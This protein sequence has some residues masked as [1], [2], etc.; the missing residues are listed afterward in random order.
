MG[1]EIE[2]NWIG[3]LGRFRKALATARFSATM[4]PIRGLN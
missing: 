4:R 3:K 2:K 1:P